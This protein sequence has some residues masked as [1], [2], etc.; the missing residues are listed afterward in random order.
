MNK[1]QLEFAVQWLENQERILQEVSEDQTTKDDFTRGFNKGI[2]FANK[3]YKKSIIEL[4]QI[5][6][7]C[8]VDDVDFDGGEEH[9]S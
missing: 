2:R 1:H 3:Y 9:A 4:R 8:L 7:G 5:L 6:D